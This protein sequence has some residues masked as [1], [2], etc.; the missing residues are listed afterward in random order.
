[1]ATTPL[2]PS[3]STDLCALKRIDGALIMN[4]RRLYIARNAWPIDMRE[5]RYG[6][7]FSFADY[8]KFLPRNLTRI[9]SKT[10]YQRPSGDIAIF[11]GDYAYLTDSNF[12]LKAG[13]SRPVEYVGFPRDAR[14]NAA[15]NTHAGHS[16]SY[17]TTIK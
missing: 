11:A 12:H 17:T 15:I 13:W 8:F 14:I 5:R 16:V 6:A 2:A 10:M 1:M 4:H 7:P 9:S 3:D